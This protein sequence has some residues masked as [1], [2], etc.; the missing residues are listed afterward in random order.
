LPNLNFAIVDGA[1]PPA[2]EDQVY[3]VHIEKACVGMPTV[4][5]KLKLGERLPKDLLASGLSAVDISP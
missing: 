5:E 1:S 2:P 4:L 3:L